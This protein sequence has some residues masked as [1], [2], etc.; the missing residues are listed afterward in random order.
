[1][2]NCFARN[3][4]IKREAKWKNHPLHAS[5]SLNEH[6]ISWIEVALSALLVLLE[7]KKQFLKNYDV[8]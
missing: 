7:V 5:Q 6:P 1:L 8:I 4:F 2:K 3:V